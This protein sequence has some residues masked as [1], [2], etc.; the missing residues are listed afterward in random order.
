RAPARRLRRADRLRPAGAGR[1]PGAPLAL[2]PPGQRPRVGR[3]GRRRPGPVR[4]RRLV[5]VRPGGRRLAEPSGGRAAAA[6]TSPGT[7]G[8]PNARK[9]LLSRWTA[10]QPR[11]REKHVLVTELH[12]GEEGEVLAVEL[13]AVRTRRS[14]RID[15][16]L[17]EDG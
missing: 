3:A 13:Q 12:C 14:E 11:N 2:R 17:L 4:L 7:P 10:R 5:P 15:W 9:L 6:G 8:R 1:Q 16:R